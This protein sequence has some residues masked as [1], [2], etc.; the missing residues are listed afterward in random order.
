ME[1]LTNE[2]AALG[3]RYGIA[4]RLT[5]A[6][7][8]GGTVAELSHDGARAIVALQG[9]QVLSYEADGHG[10]VLWLSPQARLGTGKAVRGGIP[11]CWPWFGPH[12]QGGSHPAHGFVRTQRWWPVSTATSTDST[13]IKLAC[14]AAGEGHSAWPHSARL[15]LEIVLGQC[16]T[17]FLTTRNTGTSEFALTQALHS[18]FRVDDIA[19]VDVLGLE[20]VHFIDQLDSGAL[21]TEGGAVRIA[22]EIDRVYQG[23]TETVTIADARRRIAI[24]SR[25]CTSVVLWNPWIDKS[26][27][28]GDMGEDGYRRMLCL[29]TANAGADVITLAP[30]ESHTLTA[31]ISATSAR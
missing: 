25:G 24:Q 3:Q 8:H 11:V 4:R 15:E 2:P 29:E 6:E 31:I 26:A 18:Y 30:G 20:D 9:A 13:R 16:L 10:E 22:G 1:S 21:K 23:L 19:D 5:F 7:M 14:P 12:P 28:L 17:L 27:R